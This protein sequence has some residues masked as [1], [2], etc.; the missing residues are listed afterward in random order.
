MATDNNDFLDGALNEVATE[1]APGNLRTDNSSSNIMLDD[2]I[3]S[4]GGEAKAV[5][6][7]GAL[8]SLQSNPDKYA[9]H[10]E[11]GKSL[12]L[13]VDV[14]GRNYDRLKQVNTAQ[15]ITRLLDKNASLGRWYTDGDNHA[16]IKVDELRHY[17]GLS[18]LLSSAA[19]GWSDGR[20]GVDLSNLRYR[21]LMGIASEDE[22]AAADRMSAAQEERTFGADT[23]LQRGWV[24]AAQQLPNLVES[25]AG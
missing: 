6:Y 25:F 20:E 14:V 22:I 7:V 8:Q 16:T 9:E 21:Q 13:P 10:F 24:G 19:Q 4:V 5:N 18:W 2:A 17:D 11:L 3:D 12:G 15:T 23:W 1:G